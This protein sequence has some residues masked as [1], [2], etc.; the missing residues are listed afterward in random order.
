MNCRRGSV[1]VMR[2]RGKRPTSLRHA[3]GVVAVVRARRHRLPYP[4]AVAHPSRRRTG[5]WRAPETAAPPGLGP[6]SYPAG[7]WRS[8]GG[9]YYVVDETACVVS[10]RST[11]PAP[12]PPSPA[13][14]PAAT[15]RS[16]APP[17]LPRS[18]PNVAPAARA[19]PSQATCTC[20]TR[21][22]RDPPHRRLRDHH[23]GHRARHAA[24]REHRR[25][26]PSQRPHR[27]PR[28]HDLRRVQ[29]TVE[30]VSP[31]GTATPFYSPA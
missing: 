31:D 30:R 6:H 16:T 22:R 29:L 3:L 7:S 21:Q 23:L 18:G 4:A 19:R 5:T 20:P 8:P 9:G 10:A 24:V 26:Y 11:P 1:P 13:T 27:H 15:R 2:N 28:R 12:S 17:R 25:T 14:A